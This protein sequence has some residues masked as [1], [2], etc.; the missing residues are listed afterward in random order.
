MKNNEIVKTTQRE[1]AF[2]R[3]MQ[4]M[5]DGDITLTAP[6][7]EILHRWLYCDKLLL[8]RKYKE[9]QIIEKIVDTYG[10]SKYT[11]KNDIYQAQALM[12][13]VIKPNKKYLLHHHAEG[14]MLFIE[15]CKL[16]KSLVYLVPKLLDAYTKAVIAMPDEINKDKMPPPQMNFFIIP[17]QQITVSKSFEDAI[18]NMN[19]RSSPGNHTTDIDYEEIDNES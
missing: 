9:E 7:E 13:G 2:N 5:I 8:Q 10:V 14:I 19:K 18:K 12:G 3:I 17:G 16:D 11:A 6:E 4:F 1:N 15:R